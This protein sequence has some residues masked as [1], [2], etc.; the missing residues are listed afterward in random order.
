MPHLKPIVLTWPSTHI[1]LCEIIRQ[2][3]WLDAV[4]IP[5]TEASEFL[6]TKAPLFG[7]SWATKNIAKKPWKCC[8]RRATNVT[9]C[10]V[11]WSRASH[12]FNWLINLKK[13]RAKDSEK[14][15]SSIVGTNVITNV[16][17][18]EFVT[19]A[20]QSSAT[21]TLKSFVPPTYWFVVPVKLNNPRS[22]FLNALRISGR[23][24]HPAAHQG[25]LQHD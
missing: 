13:F 23:L 24:Q 1:T 2:S 12:G 25:A 17:Q 9:F 15:F 19:F 6:C 14:L 10:T 11:F 18:N 7:G 22:S 3:A 21:S 5:L 4:T 16:K 8:L 20:D